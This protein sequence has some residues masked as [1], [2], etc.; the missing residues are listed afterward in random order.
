[1]IN[2]HA[3]PPNETY[4][5][6]HLV[7]RAAM[8]AMRAMLA[9]QPAADLGTSGRAAF[10]ELMAKTP[11]AENVLYEAAVVGGIPGW[12]CRPIE[13]SSEAAILYLHGGAYVVGSAQAY[14]HFAG[15]I[16]A[17]A[18]LPVF[19]AD[20]GLA[21]ERPFPAAVDDAEA[22]YR[23]LALAGFSSIAVAGDSAGGGLALVTA[24]RMT[25]AARTDR[26]HRPFAVCVMSPWIDLALAS[27]SIE[28]R[29][30]RDPLLSRSSLEGARQRY[31]GMVNANDP[32][33]SPVYGDLAGLP[34]VLLHVGEDEV[35]LDDAR[36]YS[37]RLAESGGK[38]ELHVWEGMVH[39]FP[40]NIS[41]L[42]AAH[43]A[44]DIVGEFL[45]RE[46]CE[47]PVTKLEIEE[48]NDAHPVCR[49][50]A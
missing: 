2:V 18:K 4:H 7:D 21:P 29:A 17:R 16:A 22:A 5:H 41:L 13:A 39:V 36:R 24:A 46:R 26:I 34:P 25:S 23:G 47:H 30:A 49:S 48:P 38:V 27:E 15:Q 33:A 1:M 31:L 35:L 44:L 3:T 12:W 42:R 20:Y 40:A 37:D 45:R 14:R 43:E 32:R 19:I 6:E 50:E 8:L 28:T 11:A 10:D 9:L